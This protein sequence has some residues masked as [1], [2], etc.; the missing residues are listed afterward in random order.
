MRHTAQWIEPITKPNASY[1]WFTVAVI[2]LVVLRTAFVVA[3]FAADGELNRPDSP[4]YLVLAQNLSNLGWFSVSGEVFTPEVFRTPGYPA[5]LALFK[6][7]GLDAAYWPIA[8]QHI[9]YLATVALFFASIR[10]LLDPSIARAGTLF[11][12]I[13]P[14]GLAYPSF[15]L[16]D[17]VSLLL[18]TVSVLSLGFFLRDRKIPLLLACGVLLGLAV[19][20]RPGTM[21]LPV[22]FACVIWVA[23]GPSLSSVARGTTLILICILVTGPWLIRNHAHFGVPYVSAQA[24]N[25]FANYH[26]PFVWE[27]ARGIPFAEGQQVFADTLD[28]EQARREQVLHRPLNLVESSR[29]RQTL[30]LE[31]IA[32]YP[33]AYAY[34]WGIGILKTLFGI[35]VTEIYASFHLRSDRLH[36]FEINETAITKKLWIFLS[37]QDALV[38]A[39]VLMRMI[40]TAFALAGAVAIVRSR[41]PFLFAI[42]LTSAYF[43]FLPGPM[44][45]ARMRFPIEGMLFIQA[46]LGLRLLRQRVRRTV[47]TSTPPYSRL[48]AGSKAPPSP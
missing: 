20:V 47:R 41:D 6:E 11:L 8:V 25:M 32:R 31:E 1:D 23:H 33:G 15:F 17:T 21:Y 22:V 27:S 38:A 46:W 2:L 5:F 34:Q 24:S 4:L 43:V 42:A 3:I 7:L 14:G 35:S 48:H 16:S 37:H 19:L 26:V 12:L 9:L 45:L 39:E 30:A 10:Q 40:L 36:Y 28:A 29:M 18:I 44:G 13:E